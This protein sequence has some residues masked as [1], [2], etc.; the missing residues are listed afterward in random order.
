MAQTSIHQSLKLTPCWI[1]CDKHLEWY[2]CRYTEDYKFKNMII[3]IKSIILNEHLVIIIKIKI[4]VHAC[5]CLFCSSNQHQLTLTTLVATT[6]SL[7]LRVA[8]R[9][10]V[11]VTLISIRKIIR[12][13]K[14]F[15]TGI[16]THGF[17]TAVV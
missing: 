8:P 13:A 5:V 4:I 17:I 15:N 6:V 16:S 11:V 9:L 1:T 3:N 12:E 14:A 7:A 10:G 2:D